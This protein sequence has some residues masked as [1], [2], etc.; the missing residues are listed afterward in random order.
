[1]EAAATYDEMEAMELPVFTDGAADDDSID[2]AE[3]FAAAKAVLREAGLSFDALPSSRDLFFDESEAVGF[4]RKGAS[5]CVAVGTLLALLTLA[6][7]GY[8]AAEDAAETTRHR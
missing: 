2:E 5:L 8:A 4:F 7:A 3:E 6:F 1:M